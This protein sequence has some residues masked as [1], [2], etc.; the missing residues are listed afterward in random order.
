[1]LAKIRAST[2]E[3]KNEQLVLVRDQWGNARGNTISPNLR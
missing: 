2:S 1:M 3:A